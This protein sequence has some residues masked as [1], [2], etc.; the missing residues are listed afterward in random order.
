VLGFRPDPSWELD[1]GY[2]GVV[3]LLEQSVQL[4][5]QTLETWGFDPGEPTGNPYAGIIDNPY[6]LVAGSYLAAVG[7]VSGAA[8]LTEA[9]QRVPA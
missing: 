1:G 8:L 2:H 9:Y 4:L 7:R 5:D 6:H 3:P